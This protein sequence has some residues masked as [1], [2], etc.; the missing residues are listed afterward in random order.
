MTKLLLFTGKGGVG[1]S[2]SSAATALYYSKQG[3]KTLLV[4]SDPA[5]ST[6]DTVGTKIGD[7]PREISP[8]L[9]A[10]NINAAV[11]TQE[12]QQEMQSA[13]IS[14][15]GKFIPSL[16]D[17]DSEMSKVFSIN[18]A[19]PGIDEWG[20]A[21]VMTQQFKSEQYDLVIFDTAPTGHTLKALAAPA[22]VKQFILQLRRLKSKVLGKLMLFKSRN[23]IDEL[24][25]TLGKFCDEIDELRDNLADGSKTKIIL[26]S[27]PTEAGFM[28]FFRTVK[29]LQSLNLN[30][31]TLVLN[32]LV[33]DMGSEVW[34]TAKDN[35]AVTM[36]YHEYRNQQPWIQKYQKVCAENTIRLV[37]SI[38][39]PYEPKGI[40]SDSHLYD[41]AELICGTDKV[42]PPE[43][44]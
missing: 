31:H 11:V 36:V 32:H 26:V 4:S 41:F 7:T 42:S 14:T 23:D 18:N 30:P 20:A 3:L 1:K 35:P 2:T 28:E 22:H 8:N 29:Y 37:G 44:S 10:M 16:S 43:E 24:E 21:E 17:N 27:I 6:D 15:F 25:L 38:R 9:W 39:L 34:A 13:F 5:H 33:P 12:R 19:I 40:N